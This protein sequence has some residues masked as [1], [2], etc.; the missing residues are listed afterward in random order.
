[1]S[2]FQAFIYLLAAVISV[3]LAKRLGLGSVLGYLLA[4]IAIGP[5]CLRLVG[6]AGGVM[7]FAEFG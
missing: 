4:G 6:G 2:F 3:P 1:M 7:H 5:F